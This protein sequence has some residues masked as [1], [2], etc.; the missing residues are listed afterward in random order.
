[1][2]QISHLRF[3]FLLWC[4]EY[5][6]SIYGSWTSQKLGETLY[7]ELRTLKFSFP[8]FQSHFPV[9]RVFLISVLLIFGT[10]KRKDGSCSRVLSSHT[11]LTVVC[12]QAKSH[13]HGAPLLVSPCRFYL[14]CRLCPSPRW[15]MVVVTSGL[16]GSRGCLLTHALGCYFLICFSLAQDHLLLGI[17]IK[18]KQLRPLGW[19]L[20]TSLC[21]S[22]F[23]PSLN[24]VTLKSNSSPKHHN[25]AENCSASLP[26]HRCIFSYLQSLFPDH[27]RIGKCPSWKIAQITQLTLMSFPSFLG[28]LALLSW[29]L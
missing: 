12:H 21:S 29:L 3:W 15:K 26:L 17:C 6:P 9:T 19:F 2:A 16:V 25:I 10:E 5:V 20:S 23:K 14:L 27:L 28:V 24:S 1:M 22:I 7:T 4:L 11:V 13:K 18:E 8:G